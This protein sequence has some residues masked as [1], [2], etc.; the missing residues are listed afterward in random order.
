MLPSAREPSHMNLVEVGDI[1]SV[2]DESAFSRKLELVLVEP[3][4]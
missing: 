3:A 4:R 2:E 1:A